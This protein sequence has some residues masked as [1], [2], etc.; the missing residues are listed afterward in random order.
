MAPHAVA[1]NWWNGGVTTPTMTQ[2]PV[3]LS[4]IWTSRMFRTGYLT[5]Q[6]AWHLQWQCELRVEGDSAF[7]VC[8]TLRSAGM[9]HWG[10]NSSPAL[11]V[12]PYAALLITPAADPSS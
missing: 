9:L 11:P 4:S 8:S 3:R 7:C 5:P 12:A 10:L 6:E 1:G 2:N